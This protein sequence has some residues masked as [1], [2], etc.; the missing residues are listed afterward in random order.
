LIDQEEIYS[1][2]QVIAYADLLQ[3][4]LIHDVSIL[5]IKEQF[6]RIVTQHETLILIGLVTQSGLIRIK[7]TPQAMNKIL[8]LN[9]IVTHI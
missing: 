8:M 9:T 5:T 1:E 7:T 6:Q 2:D 4:D 3:H